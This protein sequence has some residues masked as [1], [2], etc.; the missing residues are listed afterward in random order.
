MLLALAHA[1]HAFEA[2]RRDEQRRLRVPH[3]ERAEQL[4][5]VGE[6][7]AEVPAGYHGV[8]PLH[9][10]EVV[11]GQR[12]GRVRRERAPEGLHRG[13]LKLHSRRHPVPAEADEVL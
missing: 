8:H 12:R 7:E 2:R 9:R 1:R 5:V 4:E 11:R 6:V 13:G 3:P 10:D